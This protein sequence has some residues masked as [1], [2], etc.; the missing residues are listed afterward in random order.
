MGLQVN[1]SQEATFTQHLHQHAR[2]YF[3]TLP[4]KGV[5]VR[6]AEK[7]IRNNSKLY[8]FEIGADEEHHFVYVKVPS[9]RGSAGARTSQRPYLIP[10]TNSDLKFQLH[11][12]GLKVIHEHF[13][14]LKDSRFGTV[15]ALDLLPESDAFVMEEASGQIIRRILNQASRFSLASAPKQLESAF[16]NAGV[17]L[18]M[19]HQEVSPPDDVDIV[20]GERGDY[21]EA[22]NR[23]AE[24]LKGALKEQEFFE[25]LVKTI[26]ENVS[27]ILPEQ[28]PLGLRF[29]DYGLTNILVEANGRVTGIDTLARW[30]APIYEDIAWFLTALKA[31]NMQA[32]SQGLAFSS[33]RVKQLEQEFLTGYFGTDTIPVAEIRLYE[34]LRLLE[35]WSAKVSRN[36]SKA[37][38]VGKVRSA[39]VNRFFRKTIRGLLEASRLA[40]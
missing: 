19:Y 4:D 22:I 39:L 1:G 38:L 32:Y 24:F 15:R 34:I 17:W 33:G 29:G 2:D 8:R 36:Q 16:H 10:E 21:V 25:E 14:Q 40:G 35:R 37:G 30:R 20:H 18:Q 5:Y 23:F 28:L 11:Y 6:L 7:W 27:E 31:Y 3:P 12:M 9:V 13:E 26:S